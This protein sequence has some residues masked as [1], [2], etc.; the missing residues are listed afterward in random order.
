[1]NDF[2]KKLAIKIVK[3]TILNQYLG[4]VENSYLND[5]MTEAEYKERIDIVNIKGYA[6]DVMTKAFSDGVMISPIDNVSLESKHVKFSGKE[7]IEE[8]KSVAS[9]LA[10]KEN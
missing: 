3:D 10:L 6:D 7:T 8:I 4:D 1:M 2:K 5:E 9:T